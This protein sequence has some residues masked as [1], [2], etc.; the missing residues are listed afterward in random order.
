MNK[1]EYE[2]LVARFAL[3]RG[4]TLEIAQRRLLKMYMDLTKESLTC[5]KRI[6]NI[7]LSK[8][9]KIAHLEELIQKVSCWL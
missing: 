5:L 1:K 3:E 4:Y 8:D 7:S 2:K 6:V 9:D